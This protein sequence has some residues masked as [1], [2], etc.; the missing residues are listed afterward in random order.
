MTTFNGKRVTQRGGMNGEYGQ[1]LT[2]GAPAEGQC[3]GAGCGE[4]ATDTS[5]SGDPMCSNCRQKYDEKDS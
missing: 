1:H 5:F 3:H 4:K 2:G